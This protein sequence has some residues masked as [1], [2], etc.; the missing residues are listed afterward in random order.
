[1]DFI[2]VGT[3]DLTQY[4]LAVDR[5]NRDVAALFDELHPA[6]LRAL[7]QIAEAAA[8][9]GTEVSICGEMA[10]SPLAAV[11]LLGM[12]VSSLSMSAG[13]LLPVKAVIR[14]IDRP[15]ARELLLQA[16]D[17]D[18]AAQVRH[19]LADALEEKGLGGLVRPGR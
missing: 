15:S 18:N 16:L 14:S 17:C 2:S 7:C 5:N 3:N 10:G 12:G 19:L 1:V 11:L 6:V 8:N 9:T 13:S 4:L